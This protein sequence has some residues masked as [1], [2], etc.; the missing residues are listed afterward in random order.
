MIYTQK[1]IYEYLLANPLNV[2]VKI[3]DAELVNGRDYIFLSYTNESLINSDDKPL[4]QTHLQITIATKD[5]DNR[6]ILTNYVKDYLNVSVSY[7]V[8]NGFEYYISRLTCGVL[9][10]E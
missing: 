8:S 9:M 1:D 7:D 6:K 5:F 10:Y 4:Y 2:E 3:G